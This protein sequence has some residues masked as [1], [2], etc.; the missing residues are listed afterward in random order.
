MVVE[1]VERMGRLGV[2]VV[3]QAGGMLG[4]WLDRSSC[5]DEDRL[6]GVVVVVGLGFLVVQEVREVL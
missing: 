6:V 3:R 4:R 5:S 2:V 1:V